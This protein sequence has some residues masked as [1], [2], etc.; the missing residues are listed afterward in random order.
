MSHAPTIH[1]VMTLLKGDHLVSCGDPTI[2]NY[3]ALRSTSR[4]NAEG[5]AAYKIMAEH[6]EGAVGK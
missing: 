4:D 6:L 1:L 5:I 2:L 3:A